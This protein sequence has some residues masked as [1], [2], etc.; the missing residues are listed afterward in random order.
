[1]GVTFIGGKHV[2]NEDDVC[3]FGPLRFW[4]ERGLIHIEDSRDNSYESVSMRTAL[5]RV[6]A[7]S[8]MLG[9]SSKRELYS[10]DQFDQANRVRHQQMIE[11]MLRIFEKAKIQGMPSDPSARRDLVRR[12]PVSVVVPGYGSNL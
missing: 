8:E 1:M 6:S 7:I 3:I 5:H 4:A 11:R 2:L 9:N 12:R 10:E